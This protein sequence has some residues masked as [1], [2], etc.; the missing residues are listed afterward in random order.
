MLKKHVTSL[1]RVALCA[2]FIHALMPALAHIAD[3]GHGG[4]A[5]VHSTATS[6]SFARASDEDGSSHFPVSRTHLAGIDTPDNAALQPATAARGFDDFAAPPAVF[7]EAAVPA[8]S[9]PWQP[10]P[11]RAPPQR[12]V[13]A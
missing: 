7:P 8:I 5:V 2:L 1:L 13:E 11:P 10:G 9:P 3:T 4:R 12:G 6:L